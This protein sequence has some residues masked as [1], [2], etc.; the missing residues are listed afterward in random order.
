MKKKDTI[1]TLSG[2]DK[3]IL[4]YASF[5]DDIDMYTGP[6][7]EARYFTDNEVFHTAANISRIVEYSFKIP[8][9]ALYLARTKN[10]SAL[11]EWIPKELLILGIPYGGFLQVFRRYDRVCKEYYGVK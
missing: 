7:F 1:N 5:V 6:F 2:L 4:K 8:F 10:Y 9:I 3:F 11:H